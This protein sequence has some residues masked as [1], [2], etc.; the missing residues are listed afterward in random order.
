MDQNSLTLDGSAGTVLP[1]Q[2]DV[3]AMS[4]AQKL[5][6]VC[7]QPVITRTI[8]FVFSHSL[9]I[10]DHTGSFSGDVKFA[11]YDVRSLK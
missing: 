4:V 10:A 6:C 3:L 7:L 9:R 11:Y 5:G 2:G 8:S 1:S